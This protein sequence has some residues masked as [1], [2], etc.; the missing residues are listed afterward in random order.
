MTDAGRSRRAHVPA[1]RPLG[2]R[3]LLK[4]AAASS[5]AVCVEC[6]RVRLDATVHSSLQQPGAAPDGPQEHDQFV[7]A[8]GGRAG[9]TIPPNG[10]PLGGPQVFAWPRDP[11]T[12]TVR[13]SSRLNQVI[14]IRLDPATLNADTAQRAADGIVAYSAVC[15]HTGC[16]VSDWLN[17]SQTLLCPCHESEFDPAANARVVL[18]PARTRLASLALRIVN[19]A[20]I[21]AGS[22]DGWVGPAPQV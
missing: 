18:G 20:L 7:F 12:G 2:R 19:G 6:A 5:L 8:L 15:P 17:A 16:D 4:T 13:D 14:L 10:V 1:G 3:T 22:F 11:A 9:T 21:S